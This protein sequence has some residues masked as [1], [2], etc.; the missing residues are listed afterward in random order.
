MHGEE[1]SGVA[2]V[3]SSHAQLTTGENL[4]RVAAEPGVCVIV[5]ITTAMDWDRLCQAGFVEA[6]SRQ[7]TRKGLRVYN[8]IKMR[9]QR[10][11]AK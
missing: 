9:S 3:R 10:Y 11:V 2:A 6:P 8:V 7:L 1:R 5:T 4:V